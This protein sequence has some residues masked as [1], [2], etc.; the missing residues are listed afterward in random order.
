MEATPGDIVKYLKRIPL[1]IGLLALLAVIFEFGFDLTPFILS[2][3]PW[4]YMSAI[5]AG[6]ISLAGR[7]IFIKHR[8]VRNILIYDMLLAVYLAGII[9][10]LAGLEH[11]SFFY[12]RFLIYSGVFLVL[13]REF[14]YLQY[15]RMLQYLNPFQLFVTTYSAII[16][17]GTILLML[18]NATYTGI[19]LT[20]ALFTSTSAFCITGLVVVDTGTYFTTFG[21]V[22]IL[23]L[24]Q[25]G[26]IGIMTFTSFFAYFF[27]GSS[28]YGSQ[29]LLKDM[30]AS[31]KI[32]EVFSTVKIIILFTLIIEAAGALFIYLSLDKQVISSIQER[33]YFSVFHSVSGFC[34]AGFTTLSDSLYDTAFRFNYSLH[35]I[36]ALLFVVG[37]LGFPLVYNFFK[38]LQHYLINRIL[39]QRALHVPWVI[40]MNTRIVFI[41]TLVLLAGGTF[42]F[43]I[44]EYDNTLAVHEGSGKVITAFF[45]AATPRS[46]G[47]N[48][49]DTSAL[50]LPALMLVIFLMWIGAAPGSTGGGIKVTSFA[51]A[52]MNVVSIA[53]GKDRIE[54][55]GRE[56]SGESVRRAFA[57]ILLSVVT[58]GLSVFLI[59]VLD[60]DMEILPVVFECFSAYSTVGLSMGITGDLSD[61]GKLIIIF[62]M[63]TGRIGMLVILQALLR[64]VRHLNYRYPAESILT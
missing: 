62:N 42:L 44:L 5:I 53:R 50:M 10:G 2:L 13:I 33:I 58:I 14:S 3:L 17:S 41:T 39:K 56:V 15:S 21:Q 37:G 31:E 8:P 4:I 43:Y 47:F 1:W 38:Y 48:T 25:L 59:T 61:A 40:N 9:G 35:L 64:D 29:L 60:K 7:H 63:F 45:S 16:V 24:I 54:V 23:V 18:P 20:D 27:T 57:V 49:V 55:F 52:V 11:M 46:A 28:T 32:A 22:I 26:G 51:V 19:S 6:L 12:N 36:I 30:T 34:S